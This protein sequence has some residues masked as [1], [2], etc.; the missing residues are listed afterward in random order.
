VEVQI[1][2]GNPEYLDVYQIRLVAGR[3]VLPSDTVKELLIN[4]RL[5]HALGFQRPAD[6][7]GKELKWNRKKATIVGI[8][9]D[10]HDMS[11]KS[12]IGA[13]AFGGANGNFIHVKLQPNTTGSEQWKTT[14]AQIQLAY[15]KM[16]PESDFDYRFMDETI[17]KFYESEQHTASL[18]T[19]ATGLAILISCLGL[20]G[21]VI[22][23]T[24]IRTK[25]IGIRKILGASVTNIISILSKDFIQLVL[26]AFI[27][28]APLAWWASY[29]WLQ[30]FVYRTNMSW[31]IFA[32][33]G[34]AMLVAAVIT[35]SLQ[36][37]KT[38]TANPVK[39]LRSE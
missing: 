6:I 35:L 9:K 31:W 36:T 28:A 18:L 13:V 34:A 15:K 8:M 21:L 38:A 3:N 4:E 10:F 20:L 16:Y 25:E 5:A 12:A 39:S 1:R 7:L 30:D 37:I 11:M 19:W 22:Y 33:S 24:S 14:I 26:L 17:A 32:L 29:K 27:I 2:W 23:T